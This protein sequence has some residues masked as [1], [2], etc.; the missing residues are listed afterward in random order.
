M[1]HLG[2]VKDGLACDMA[3]TKLNQ[4]TLVHSSIC[5]SLRVSKLHKESLS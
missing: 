1:V 2:L 4:K 3:Q 5:L